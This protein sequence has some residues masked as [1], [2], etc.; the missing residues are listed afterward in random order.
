MYGC[1][2][3]HQR[4]GCHECLRY[5]HCPG[6]HRC[7]HCLH[8]SIMG[9]FIAISAPVIIV[10]V[11]AISTLGFMGAFTLIIALY[12]MG[13]FADFCLEK[14][15]LTTT[16]GYLSRGVLTRITQRN[17]AIKFEIHDPRSQRLTTWFTIFPCIQILQIIHASRS[18]LT[19]RSKRFMYCQ[20]LQYK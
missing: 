4:H 2:H 14:K 16:V 8:F 18:I 5:H 19:N 12:V 17:N 6:C 11:T 13:A 7:L 10:A 9:A 20:L 15:N 1:L 3:W